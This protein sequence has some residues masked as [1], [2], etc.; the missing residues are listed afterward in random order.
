MKD[1]ENIKYNSLPGILAASNN[2]FLE[3]CSALYS[4]HYGIWGEKGPHPGKRVK[5]SKER[6]R[7]W[8]END[9]VV[10]YYA[11]R[12][13]KIV[14]YA[15]AF[16]K[17]EL[18]YGIVT[19]VTQL[20]VHENYRRH[21]IAK[22]LLFSIW[23]FSDHFAWGIVSANP[24]AIR[25]LEK[26]T[27]RR[28]I[29]VRIKRNHKKLKNI[30]KKDVPFIDENTEFRVGKEQSA[31]NTHFFVSHEDTYHMICN[32][33]AKTPWVLGNIEEGWEWLAFTFQDQEQI[34]L[35]TEEIENMVSTADLVVHQAY[36][37]M[38]V[39]TTFQKWMKNTAKEIEYIFEKSKV[40]IPCLVY[41]LGCGAGRH[42]LAIA[43]QG[44][45]VVGIDYV[46]ENI[47]EARKEAKRQKLDKAI[48]INADC[49]EYR[50]VN[51]AKLVLCLYDVVGSFSDINDNLKI[52]QTAYDLL[53][54]SGFAF[55][56]VMNYEMTLANAKYTFDFETEANQLLT[57]PASNI[58]ETTGNVFDPQCY[59]VD[60]N[61]HLVYRKEQFKNG[62]GLPI[63]LIVRDRRF[64]MKEILDL[65]QKV[66][67]T[68]I[69][70]K[71]TN[72][73]DWTKEYESTS[74]RAKE[75]LIVCQK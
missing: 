22:N 69:E 58:M 74:K 17:Y 16:S 54:K 27:R 64:T 19:W 65:C 71:Y 61:T 13:E 36:T 55:F 14:G 3:E 18:H 50:N 70:A 51:L 4:N 60:I 44:G 62:L 35:S 24:Y 9:A 10:I 40:P 15:I 26:A 38:N 1:W 12:G 37:R 68:I 6:L 32:A 8:L 28:A 73:S 52:I 2:F 25:A 20:V 42:S 29:P 59:M 39:D 45:Q 57:L 46:E 11:T 63:E 34:S 7:N 56:S 23:G 43:K 75:I 67:F 48:F 41:D 21:G 31:V 33:S 30:G 47:E 66:G 5:I 49:R 72:A 53:D